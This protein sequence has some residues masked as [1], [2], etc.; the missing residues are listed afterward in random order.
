MSGSASLFRV[1]QRPSRTTATA[2]VVLTAAV[3][4]TAAQLLAPKEDAV[5]VEYDRQ[6]DFTKYRTYA[7]AKEQKP[8]P[9][10]ANHIRL[11]VAVQKQLHSLGYSPD[12]KEP[13]VRI[14]YSL[15]DHSKVEFDAFVERSGLS[16]SPARVFGSQPHRVTERTLGVA[17][18]DAETNAVV[19]YA[20]GTREV[21]SPDKEERTLND[22]VATLFAKYPKEKPKAK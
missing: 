16:G 4:A 10:L 6:R 12:T 18:V 7:W 3:G 2:A 5:R 19:W 1:R 22:L 13:D 15:D 14:L 17:L 11:T 21:E 20:T 9:S 8:A